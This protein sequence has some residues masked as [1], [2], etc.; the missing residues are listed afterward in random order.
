MLSSY[1]SFT[2]S[3][4]SR[5][6]CRMTAWGGWRN[7][8]PHGLPH[9]RFLSFWGYWVVHRKHLAETKY[10][11]SA[12]FLWS[13][14]VWLSVWGKPSR[15]DALE[16]IC[17]W[18]LLSSSSTSCYSSSI[19]FYHDL[20]EYSLFFQIT[21]LHHGCKCTLQKFWRWGSRIVC[22]PLFIV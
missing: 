2:E 4:F 14:L 16:T 20:E 10:H 12:W 21:N 19:T 6:F 17:I 13:F 22:N 3:L 7:N 15:N 5:I 1:W 11:F 8:C 18:V 9:S